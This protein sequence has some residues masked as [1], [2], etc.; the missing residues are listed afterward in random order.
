MGKGCDTATTIDSAKLQT[1]VDGDYTF[2][3][4]YL[5]GIYAL[6][7]SEKTTITN[8]DLY[9][10]SLFEY[11]NSPSYFTTAHGTTDAENAIDA[12]ETIGQPS[13]TPIY[14]AVD[15][16]A[17]D[18]DISSS[19]RDYLQ[20]IKAVFIDQNYPYELGL[21]GCG[22]AL[23]YFEN[24]YTYTWLAGASAW[25]GSSTYTGW[26]LKQSPSTTIGSGSGS[27]LIDP[28]ESNGAAGGWQ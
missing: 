9:I 3:G 17:P 24:T 23:D 6:T 5:T 8:G 12:A 14:F 15:Y 11:G 21:Y 25:N 13:G 7:T 2:V 20:A 10:V 27:I 28:D 19:I 22:A 18:N 1:L 4:R 16:D 26:A